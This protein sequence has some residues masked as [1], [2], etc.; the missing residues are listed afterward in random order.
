MARRC[1]HR[2]RSRIC[3]GQNWSGLPMLHSHTKMPPLFW[4]LQKAVV[5]RGAASAVGPERLGTRHGT[6][7]FSIQELGRQHPASLLGVCWNHRHLMVS[8]YSWWPEK[9]VC[10]LERRAYCNWWPLFLLGIA[11]WIT[12]MGWGGFVIEVSEACCFK[13]TLTRMCQFPYSQG[14]SQPDT[15]GI[16]NSLP[17]ELL[18]NVSIFCNTHNCQL[19]NPKTAHVLSTCSLQQK[20]HTWKLTVT[21]EKFCSFLA[22]VFMCLIYLHLPSLRLSLAC[23]LAA[24]FFLYSI[25]SIILV[26]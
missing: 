14:F 20:E 9:L 24:F 1:S 7:T 5:G 2:K 8:W 13:W 21:I 10:S 3:D 16:Y 4:H 17:V 22:V 15:T 18:R 26:V 19:P 23:S 11:S 6:A 12:K 25:P